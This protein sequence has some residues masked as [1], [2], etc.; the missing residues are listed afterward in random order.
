MTKG[1]LNIFRRGMAFAIPLFFVLV[2]CKN[3]PKEVKE[4]VNEYDGPLRTQED[5]T[6]T[7]TDSGIVILRFTAATAI[8]FSHLEEE[9]YLEFPNG[10]H[11]IFYNDTGAVE[12]EIMANYAKRFIEEHYWLATGDVHVKNDKGDELE[13]EK[14][15]WNEETQRISSDESV[16]ISTPE[17][18]IW[19]KGFDADQNMEFYEIHDVY[20]TIT[21]NEEAAD[22]TDL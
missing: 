14:L 11:V 4:V 1:T 18:K 2:A 10:V 20:G 19:G 9:P 21:L 12:N 22:S 6:Y 16:A 7:Y 13:S 5:V 8:D 17:S 3:D 15:I